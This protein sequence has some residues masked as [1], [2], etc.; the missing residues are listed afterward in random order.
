[1]SCGAKRRRHERTLNGTDAAI[2]WTGA[3]VLDNAT[4]NKKASR[5]NRGSIHCDVREEEFSSS[6]DDAR[7]PL[8]QAFEVKSYGV[9]ENDSM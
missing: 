7:R 1:M 3:G 5:G 6:A 9:S 4:A 8:L 2:H